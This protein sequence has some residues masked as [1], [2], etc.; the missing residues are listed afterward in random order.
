VVLEGFAPVDEN[1]RNFVVKLMP[2]LSVAVYINFLPDKPPAAGEFGEAL[3]YHLTE[4][5]AFPGIHH[6]LTGLRHGRIVPL[7]LPPKARKKNAMPL[8]GPCRLA[9]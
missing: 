3:L 2:Q 8:E 1:D 6:H 4:V 5:T 7:P 9:R